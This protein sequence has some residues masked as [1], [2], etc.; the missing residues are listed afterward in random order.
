MNQ[1]QALA[2]LDRQLMTSDADGLATALGILVLKKGELPE[3][4]RRGFLKAFALRLAAV[5]MDPDYHR[6]QTEKGESN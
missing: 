4:V 2:E 3:H 6:P 5:V 1:K